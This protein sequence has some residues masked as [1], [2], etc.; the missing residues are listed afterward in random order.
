MN[1]YVL[2]KACVNIFDSQPYCSK[3]CNER[4][5]KI[6][7]YDNYP[8]FKNSIEKMKYL[9][10]PLD[11]FKLRHLEKYI[12]FYNKNNVYRKYSNTIPLMI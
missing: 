4:P 6:S 11:G 5:F 1:C 10:D 9:S 3:T 12:F 8:L 2:K 7:V